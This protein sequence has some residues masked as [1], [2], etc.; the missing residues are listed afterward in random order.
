MLETISTNPVIYSAPGGLPYYYFLHAYGKL[1]LVSP[2]II[3]NSVSGK[4]CPA[5]VTADTDFT[6]TGTKTITQADLDRG[7]FLE[8]KASPTPNCEGAVFDPQKIYADQVWSLNLTKTPS[9]E[10]TSIP[11]TVIFYKYIL[12]NTGNVSLT[13]PFSVSDNRIPVA[14]PQ[15]DTLVPGA[16]IECTGEHILIPQDIIDR[17]IVNI[18]TAHAAF[19]QYNIPTNDYTL[20]TVNSNTVFATVYTPPIY[21]VV[22]PSALEAI[23]ANQVITLT[24]NI[25]NI[26]DMPIGSPSVTDDLLTVDCSAATSPIPVGGSTKCTAQY[27][28]TLANMDAGLPIINKATAYGVR[29]SQPISSNTFTLNTPIK[30]TPALLA[31]LN[32]TPSTTPPNTGSTIT[33]DYVLTNTGNV[34]LTA[35]I[36]V[37]DILTPLTIDCSAVQSNFPPGTTRTCSGIYTVV[38]GDMGKGSVI[39]E[40]YATAK[41]GATVVKSNILSAIL[42]TFTGPRFI[43]AVNPDKTIVTYS[44]EPI[45]YTYTFTN[46]G[47]DD[48]Q[49]PYTVT[50]SL[51]SV[52][53]SSVLDCSLAASPLA[54]GDTTTCKSTYTVTLP[55]TIINTVSDATVQHTGGTVHASNAPVSSVATT[56]YICS[57]A[58]LTYTASPTS[59]GNGNKIVT[60]TIS[61]TVGAP[62]PISAVLISWANS[63]NGNSDYHLDGIAVTN[64]S[65]N[66]NPLPDKI[67]TYISGTGTLN[68]GSINITMT[69]SKNS[70]TG[71]GVTIV[72][73]NP[74]GTC[75]LP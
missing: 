74:Y 11:G 53:P 8:K 47:G 48:L 20:I 14:C 75:H 33:Y 6:C 18:A 25:K 39:N 2:S 55:G 3:D 27:T 57:A 60:W 10:A 30:Q 29:D 37:T 13:A 1:D 72:F 34:T 62:L 51:G 63:G 67:S 35:P 46:T 59:G 28:V 70:P 58:N 24:Y 66:L 69:F 21:M 22:V 19:N 4:S 65:L 41:F 16:S 7:F 40:G 5:S 43:I 61:N 50:S 31:A 68:T 42:A 54:P 36:A 44:G 23:A 12:T 38:Q 49:S 71:V 56:A 45:T 26:T 32:S 73:A 17:E 9:L 15:P 64:S 52:A